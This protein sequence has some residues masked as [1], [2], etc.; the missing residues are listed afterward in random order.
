MQR[1]P[2]HSTLVVS[3]GKCCAS[4]VLLTLLNLRCACLCSGT[5][6]GA[7]ACVQQQLSRGTCAAQAQFCSWPVCVQA[8]WSAA[9]TPK[10]LQQV[11]G[12][13]QVGTGGWC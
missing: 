2:S 9:P 6:A 3:L 7:D 1:Q 5:A 11:P 4:G 10:G 13:V 8:A 12:T